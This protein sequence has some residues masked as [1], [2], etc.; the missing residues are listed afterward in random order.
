MPEV[1]PRIFHGMVLIVGSV[2]QSQVLLQI[3]DTIWIGM[4]ESF[5]WNLV[6]KEA[7]HDVL[8][9]KVGQQCL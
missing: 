1:V 2:I 3:L 6:V 7:V 9:T 5:Y 8:L 4:G